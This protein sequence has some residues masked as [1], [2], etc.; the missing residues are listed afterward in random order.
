M[1]ERFSNLTPEE[2]A[3]LD[4]RYGKKRKNTWVIPAAFTFIVFIPWLM[5]SAWHHSNPEIRY[6]LVSFQNEKSGSID[7]TYLIERRDPATPLTCTLVARDIDKNVVGEI[8]DL[9]PAT[10]TRQFTKTTT[11]PTRITPVNAAVMDCRAAQD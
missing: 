3:L 9:I 5:W 8:E 10:S 4:E 11:I 2:R 1:S 6:T 7:I